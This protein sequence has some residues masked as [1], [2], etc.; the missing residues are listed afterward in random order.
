MRMGFN[1]YHR[2]ENLDFRAYP[3]GDSALQCLEVYPH[4]CF[5]VLL[6]RAPFPKHTLEGR[7]QRQL[8]L[9][10]CQINLPDPMLIFEEITRHRLLQ[11]ILPLENLY[12]AEELDAL[13][14]AYTAWLAGTKTGQVTLL[15]HPDEG[16]LVLPVGALK[17]RY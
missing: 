2:L 7:L 15:G 13:V 14:A 6:D 12:P 17:S 8:V 3:D 10:E 1:L 9:H 16:T 4:A 11:G 5:T